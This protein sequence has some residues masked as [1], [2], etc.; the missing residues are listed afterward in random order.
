MTVRRCIT[1]PAAALFEAGVLAM[2]M[3][4]DD[5]GGRTWVE[6]AGPRTAIAEADSRPRRRERLRRI[7]RSRHTQH[8][9]IAPDR[10]A[11]E[12]AK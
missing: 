12:A 3:L 5:V 7:N 8:S 4:W 6:R 10:R 2:T 9:G 11:P 1:C